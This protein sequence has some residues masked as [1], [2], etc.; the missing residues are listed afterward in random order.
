MYFIKLKLLPMCCVSYMHSLPTFNN[1]IYRQEMFQ[2]QPF[3][4]DMH[5]Q[6]NHV[7]SKGTIEKKKGDFFYNIDSLCYIM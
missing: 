2:T 3:T 7:A 6:N 4:P 5:A 1:S